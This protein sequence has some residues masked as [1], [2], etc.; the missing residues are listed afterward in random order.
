MVVDTSALI[1]ILNREEGWPALQA[2]I[3][4][5]QAAVVSAASYVEASMVAGGRWGEQGC[6]DLD[7][8]LSTLDI[9][10]VA[11]SRQQARTGRDAFL[12]YGKRR[13]PAALNFGDCF[14]YALAT[15]RDEPLLCTGTDFRLT[16]VK[17]AGSS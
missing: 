10:I 5:A 2:A 7:R 17:L 3:E 6:A 9:R 15:T 14:S 4:V 1:A 8:L 12:K 16:D 11:V 13:H